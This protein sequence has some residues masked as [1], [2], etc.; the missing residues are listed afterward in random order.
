MLQ[1][2]LRYLK[3][4]PGEE[5]V[6]DKP[7]SIPYGHP[8]D[9][10]QLN[11]EMPE[12]AT[13]G[14]T[15][16]YDP[17]AST[18]LPAGEH[19][20]KVT[21]TPYDLKTNKKSRVLTMQHKFTVLKAVPHIAWKTPQPV[22]FGTQLSRK[23]LNASCVNLPGGDY[24]YNP[25]MRAVVPVGKQTLTVTYEPDDE[26]RHNYSSTTKTV[27]IVIVPLRQP[28]FVW[29]EPAPIVYGTSLGPLQLN[30]SLPDYEDQGT[31]I[32]EP[33][34]GFTLNAG[35][36]QQ[37]KVTF[38]PFN[39]VEVSSA[40]LRVYINVTKHDSLLVWPAP[41]NV[42]VGTALS[43]A[44]L[45]ATCTNL[46]GGAFQYSHR[47]GELLPEGTHELSLEY[48]PDRKFAKNFHPASLRVTLVVMPLHQPVFTWDPPDPIV[49]LTHL[50]PQQLSAR[51]TFPTHG[52]ADEFEYST[53]APAADWS[54]HGTITFDPPLGTL[55]QATRDGTSRELSV[56]FEPFEPKE[57]K[58]AAATVNLVVRRAD[59]VIEWR[60]P[61]PVLMHTLLSAVQLNATCSL[62][63]SDSG[64]QFI[65]HP[66]VGTHL[67][68]GLHTLA[69]T[70]V[71][72]QTHKRNFNN[73]TKTVEISIEQPE[74]MMLWPTPPP[75]NCGRPLTRKHLN[76]QCVE[77]GLTPG[78][79]TFEYDPPLGS[80]LPM[81]L[82]QR[83]SVLYTVAPE[84]Q[85]SYQPTEVH[86]LVDVIPARTPVLTWDAPEPIP[87]GSMITQFQLNAR[88]NVS[89]GFL[90]YEPQRGAILASGETHTLKVTFI[91]DDPLEWQSVSLTVPIHVFKNS[92]VLRWQPDPY[93][94]AG[95]ALT[96]RHLCCTV[97]QSATFIEG[98]M[99]YK[100]K[101]GAVLAAGTQTLTATFTCHKRH[102]RE[103][104]D[105]SLSVE[106][107]VSPKV[108][109]SILWR[110]PDP[111]VFGTRLSS[112]Q[113]CARANVPG[114]FFYDPPLHALLDASEAAPLRA[115]FH[116]EN[117]IE[118]IETTTTVALHIKKAVP[119]LTW[120]PPP[121]LY[122]GAALQPKH[123]CATCKLP[124]T[125]VYCPEMAEV[126]PIGKHTM[127]VI[128]KPDASVAHNWTFA[129]SFVTMLV[130]TE[131]SLFK[132][133]QRYLEPSTRRDFAVDTKK[134]LL[135]ASPLDFYSSAVDIAPP[136][137]VPKI[138]ERMQSSSMLEKAKL[139]K[140]EIDLSFSL[141]Q[142]TDHE[143]AEVMK[144]SARLLLDA[145]LGEGV[146]EGEG[147]GEEEE[148]EGHEQV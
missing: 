65:Y 19:I 5:L 43:K 10:T 142:P 36:Q 18:V 124:G 63:G 89:E 51:L 27:D 130:I 131:G 31:I 24:L 88:C 41:A 8:L 12:F 105:A 20:L 9:E 11:A 80:I 138:V 125:W 146:G 119:V 55:L 33:P 71:P 106:L 61:A 87:F 62:P 104:A 57:V 95:M 59:P 28:V 54:D 98:V 49:Y 38:T 123:L 37:L 99:S 94:F 120:E 121:F 133:P 21:F 1:G 4:H 70:Y 45:A 101:L 30:A 82:G 110:T 73:I 32:Y 118:F 78:T 100:P 135:E 140:G 3:I 128:F 77:P 83:L 127:T 6:W 74:P 109:P 58:P 132:V 122:I 115:T 13:A 16:E 47:L 75:V 69:V 17:P 144:R 81:G 90:Y 67:P 15:F 2:L 44:Q 116:P 112:L 91:P 96:E 48:S 35:E 7:E 148:G 40:E 126:L 147:K 53:L 141:R 102:K 39:K 72:S 76:A 108:F 66:P 103:W 42:Y 22:Y 79:G 92:P 56:R 134:Y 97:E 129:S 26:H 117:T 86:V 50:G 111:I 14:G 136:E 114:E 139:A 143:L 60:H 113:L 64:A 93:F 85:Y 23:Q 107:V 46:P 68:V 145:G 29:Q 52:F 34:I 84:W 25:P 137:P